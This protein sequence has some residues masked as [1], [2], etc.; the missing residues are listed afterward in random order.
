MTP[1]DTPDSIQPTP[2]LETR[3]PTPILPHKRSYATLPPTSTTPATTRESSAGPSKLP[4]TRTKKGKARA[5]EDVDMLAHSL[6]QG[7]C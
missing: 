2:D 1:S 6:Q 4:V 3:A 7:A 5:V